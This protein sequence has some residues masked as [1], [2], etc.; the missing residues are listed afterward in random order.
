VKEH[1]IVAAAVRPGHRARLLNIS[2]SGALIETSYRLL[3]G[4]NVELL[5]EGSDRRVSM[6]GRV[7]RCSVTRLRHNT[8]CYCGAIAFD[9][10]LPWLPEPEGYP[11][12]GSEERP[13]I[14][15]ADAT[16]EWI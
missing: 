6:R 9:R 7:L 11:L 16:P 12:P 5:M 8:I 14:H 4:T 13:G 10:H 15:R 3:P 1:G 2:I